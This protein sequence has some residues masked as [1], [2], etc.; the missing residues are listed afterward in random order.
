GSPEHV[1]VLLRRQVVDDLEGK[2][3]VVGPAQFIGKDVAFPVG[4]PVGE[5]ICRNDLPADLCAAG[6]IHDDRIAARVTATDLCGEPAVS[7]GEVKYPLW[8]AQLQPSGNFR[9]RE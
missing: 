3:G 6:Q 4:Y 2:D 8:I 9:G 1:E 5:S 7:A